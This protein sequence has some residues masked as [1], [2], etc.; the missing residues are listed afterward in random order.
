MVHPF[1]CIALESASVDW[2][3][4]FEMSSTSPSQI[5]AIS[6]DEHVGQYL[7][8]VG[9]PP[10][11]DRTPRTARW[12]SPAYLQASSLAMRPPLLLPPAKTRFRS[13]QSCAA[14]VS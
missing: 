1:A 13:K 12:G 14:S 7:G 2:V 4:G 5:P 10:A 6:F 9:R 8:S 11:A 3:K